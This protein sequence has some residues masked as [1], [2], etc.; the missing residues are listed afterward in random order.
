[1]YQIKRQ[2]TRKAGNC[3]ECV[4]YA[5]CV[6]T[7]YFLFIRFLDHRSLIISLADKWSEAQKSKEPCM[8]CTYYSTGNSTMS[9]SWILLYLFLCVR[10]SF[11][12]GNQETAAILLPL[13]PR[14]FVESKAFKWWEDKGHLIWTTRG[15]LIK[16]EAQ[17]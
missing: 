2:E 6:P 13:Q 16:C 7:F 14:A 11:L 17:L 15:T 5:Y 8:N 4:L 3:D 12:S 9:K 10:H 1:M